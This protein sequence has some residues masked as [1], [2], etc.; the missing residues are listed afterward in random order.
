MPETKYT[1]VAT[2]PFESCASG[3]TT[4]SVEEEFTSFTSAFE[5]V[6]EMES[7]PLA[8]DT[9]IFVKS[10]DADHRYSGL[11]WYYATGESREAIRNGS[12][13]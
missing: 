12:G 5:W 2:L 4:I 9:G 6:R 10:Y 1:A 13:I 8:T 3:M 11:V 7:A